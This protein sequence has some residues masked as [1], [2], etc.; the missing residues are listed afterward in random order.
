[1]AQPMESFIRKAG[2][3]AGICNIVLN[4]LFSWLGNRSMADVPQSSAAVDTVITSMVMSLLMTLFISADTRRAL[5]AGAIAM[6]A[7]A[8]S[9]G[10]LLR[11]L[12][13]RPWKLGLMVGLAVA[14]VL[15]SC[16]MGLFSLLGVTALSFFAFL[17][18]KVVYSL[19]LGYAV[20]RWV[21]LRQLAAVWE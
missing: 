7:P 5:K 12:P 9:A 20:A 1:M 14:V 17:S 8:H 13:A 3:I 18:I 10:R 2:L 21:I 16:V 4:S 19:L 11:R 15:T 6:P